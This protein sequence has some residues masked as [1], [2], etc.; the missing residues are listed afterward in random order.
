[1]DSAAMVRRGPRVVI[2]P[3][4]V[5][6]VGAMLKSGWEFKMYCQRCSGFYRVPL[7]LMAHAY[8]PELSL[9]NRRIQ[10]PAVGC[11]GNCVV[12]FSTSRATPFRLLKEWSLQ[13]WCNEA[14]W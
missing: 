4:Q 10:C 12:L 14:F 9:I 5:Q 3:W 2:W 11:D 7:N 6:T 13:L 1:M 8:G